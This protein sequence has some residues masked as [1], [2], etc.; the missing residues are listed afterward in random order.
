[1]N[2]KQKFDC[3]YRGGYGPKVGVYTQRDF[4]RLLSWYFNWLE[5]IEKKVS[6]DEF[7]DKKVIDLG[8]GI[9]AFCRLLQKGGFKDVTCND[10]SSEALRLAKKFNPK[11]KTACFDIE[12]MKGENKYDLIFAFEVLEHLDKPQK[13]IKTIFN[14]L[15]RNGLFIG[16]TPYPFPK[17]FADPTHQ[18]VLSPEKWRQDFRDADFMVVVIHPMS[19]PPL[20]YRIHPR[21]NFCFPFYIKNKYFVSTTLIVAHKDG[22]ES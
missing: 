9:G 12:K 5:Y 19:F 3:Y 1:M 6:L 20:F 17:G 2:K 16:S 10:I 7:K 15:K 4:Q 11:L 14:L 8:G 22:Q 18:H 21:L 13:A